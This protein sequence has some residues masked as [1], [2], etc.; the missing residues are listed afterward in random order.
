[1]KSEQKV[2]KGI[3]KFLEDSGAYVV[4]TIVCSKSGVLDLICCINGRFVSFEVKRTDKEDN[5][6]SLQQHNIKKIGEAGGIAEVVSSIEQ[7]RQILV[8]EGL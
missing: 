5:V 3:I 8:R 2:Q 4:K 7:V 1:M 6:S